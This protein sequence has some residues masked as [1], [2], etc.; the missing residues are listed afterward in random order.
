[1]SFW[2]MGAIVRN[3]QSGNQDKRLEALGRQIVAETVTDF[4]CTPPRRIIVSRPRPGED[5]YDILPF[6]L[7]DPRFASLLS[8]YRVRSRT[9]L[10]TYERVSLLPPPTRACRQGI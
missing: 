1:M 6:F 3:E 4:S 7:R 10:E 5:A 9:T 8:H 2:M